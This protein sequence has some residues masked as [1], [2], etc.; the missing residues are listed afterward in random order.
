[1]TRES[2]SIATSEALGLLSR[3]SDQDPSAD[4][5]AQI[6]WSILSEPGD[7]TASQMIDVLGAARA[8]EL[9][10]E[11]DSAS[12]IREKLIVHGV[13][14]SEDQTTQ[15]LDRELQQG[16]ERWLSRLSYSALIEAMQMH[17]DLSGRILFDSQAQ[18]PLGLFDLEKHRP[19]LLWYRGNLSAIE[20]LANSV[21]LVG[22][23][24][25]TSYGEKVTQDMV[26]ALGGAGATILS[27]GAYG[28]DAAAHRAALALDIPTVA[29]LAGGLDSLYPRGNRQMLTRIIGEGALVSEVPAKVTP[30]KWRFL[31]RNRLIAAMAQATLVVEAGFKSGARNTA[32]HA[33]SM[34]RP[35]FAVP[36][37]ITSPASAGC[38][39]LISNRIAELVQSP[40][41]LLEVLG[42]SE[43]ATARIDSRLTS[44]ET[45]AL[46]AIGFESATPEQIAKSAG[47]TQ[48]E[49][50][51]ALGSLQ[52]SGLIARQGAEWI[53]IGRSTV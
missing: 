20:G 28:I 22:S 24:A 35:V 37:L 33:N 30:S 15:D 6:A 39:L 51:T 38:H 14:I 11:R 45:R 34:R 1:M 18:W 7:S 8:L 48:F 47:L 31:Q 23:R 53:R 41:D 13:E 5:L 29:V 40:S 46:D 27:G 43:I 10:I 19:R 44:A 4:L 25:C 12:T 2:T 16:L 36:G 49:T 3:I 17:A 32:A 50:Q 21:A 26:A 42:L 9:L 52:L